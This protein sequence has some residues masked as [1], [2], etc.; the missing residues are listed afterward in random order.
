VRLVHETAQLERRAR[1]SRQGTEQL[2][3][4]QHAR[5]LADGV[6][7]GP[8]DRV[9]PFGVHSGCCVGRPVVALEELR[10]GHLLG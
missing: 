9:A 2:G 10:P 7:G 6:L 5:V 1:L 8:A 3:K 4:A